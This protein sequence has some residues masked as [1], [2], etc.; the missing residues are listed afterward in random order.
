M[1]GINGMPS[2]SPRSRLVVEI[3]K[4]LFTHSVKNNVVCGYGVFSSVPRLPA[5]SFLR[6]ICGGVLP[7]P[8]SPDKSGA[9]F[10]PLISREK[11]GGLPPGTSEKTPHPLA[12]FLVMKD[13]ALFKS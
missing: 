13:A 7:P 6:L 9:A 10:P 4:R 1:D 8:H 5:W 11:H 2:K 12:L 3:P